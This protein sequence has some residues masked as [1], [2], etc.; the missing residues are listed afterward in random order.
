MNI[1]KTLFIALILFISFNG[2]SQTI[3]GKWK[4][5]DDE[6]GNEKSIVE[7]YKAENGKAYAKIL[8]LLEAGKEDSI[9]D[10]C[11][12]AKKDQPIKGMEIIDGLT[13]DDDEWN[14]G[15]ILDPKTGKEYK[16]IL[17]LEEMDKLK[18]RGYIGFSLIGRTQYW[19][20]LK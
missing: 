5:I 11:D 10:N 17:E 20:R 19:Y 12:G 6:T 3:F 7:I 14:S 1:K 8:Q 4:T 13:K 9:C 18:V 2:Y 15:N 16:C